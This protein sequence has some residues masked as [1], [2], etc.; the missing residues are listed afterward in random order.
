MDCRNST[1]HNHSGPIL[2]YDPAIKIKV[3]NAS[4]SVR[5]ANSLN[6]LELPLCA[7]AS[8]KDLICMTSGSE[9]NTRRVQTMSSDAMAGLPIFLIFMYG[10]KL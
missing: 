3:A 7:V 9:F 10:S 6:G 2:S 5:E 1:M 4:Y 8:K